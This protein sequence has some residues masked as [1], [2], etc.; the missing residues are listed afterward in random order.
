METKYSKYNMTTQVE[1]EWAR[2]KELRRHARNQATG[3]ERG[4]GRESHTK[5]QPS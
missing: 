2:S 4:G 5:E 1:R 3:G